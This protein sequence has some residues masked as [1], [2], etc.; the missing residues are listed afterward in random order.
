MATVEIDGS[1]LGTT[2]TNLLCCDEI[3]PG[4]SV[5]YQICK[6]LFEFHTLGSKLAAFPIKLAQ[7]QSR[8]IT[9]NVGPEEDIKK[10][11]L[12][13]WKALDCDGTILNLMTMSRV[14]GIASV[15][16]M[17]TAL[18]PMDPLDPAKL[19]DQPISFNVLDPLNTA[20]SLVLNQDPNAV[21]FLKPKGF[22]IAGTQYHPSRACV[23][24]NGKPIYISYTPSA[25]GF[26][27]RS[28]YQPILFAMKS[29]IRSQITD[30]MVVRKAGLL[31]AMIK[32]VS[33][34]VDALAQAFGAIKRTFLKMG[35][36]DN[37]LQ[38][39]QDDK[40]ETLNMQNLDGAYGMARK[41]IL[42]NIAAGDDMP[43]MMLNSETFAQGFADGSE[44]MKYV[45][46]Y[47]DN[48]RSDMHDIYAWMDNIVIHRALN[49]N[50]Y[51]T[52][53]AKF[54]EYKD[55]AYEAAFVEFKNSFS[56]GWP[57]LLTEPDSEKVRIDEVKCKAAIA[58]FQVL[59]PVCDPENKAVLAGWLA[60]TINQ[61]KTMFPIPLVLDLDAL[62]N[63]VPPQM[64]EEPKSGHPF[65]AQD[66]V[67]EWSRSPTSLPERT[68]PRRLEAVG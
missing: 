26:V 23:K 41:D 1:N 7:S 22:A 61:N 44:D 64:E 47:I 62:A 43:A 19:A 67:R 46:H 5:S 39:G 37:V 6:E 45:A 13:E 59:E 20:G 63:Y 66:A 25:F 15:C 28:V 56:A 52:I 38:V 50:W 16:L 32:T 3:Q 54:P 9:F 58:T 49:K 14:Y 33:S 36:T 40:I 68:K 55:V 2:L 12:E 30:D 4:S 53:Q 8:E 60:D 65:A 17:S 24:M 57:N 10:A 18:S 34:A 51:K 11:Y 35:V 29:F 27:G 21:D 42:E 48:I 31:I